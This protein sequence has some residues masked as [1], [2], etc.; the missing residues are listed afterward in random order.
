MSTTEQSEAELLQRAGIGDQAALDELFSMHRERL[1]SLVALRLNRKLQG[2]VNASDVLQ[3]AFLE[4]S[5]GLDSYLA[6][7]RLPFFLWLRNIAGKKLLALHR[8]HLRTQM[9]AAGREVT[10]DYAATEASMAEVAAQLVGREPSPSRAAAHN[11]ACRL[12]RDALEILDPID[13]EILTLRHFEMLSN[14]EAAQ[15][16]GIKKSAASNRY[17]RA[18]RRLQDILVKTGGLSGV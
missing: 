15:V 5:R 7:P 11:E 9:R 13:R 17:I 8:T 12:V 6:D 3:E 4:A 2:R 10:C 16:L 14:E 18:L 1:R